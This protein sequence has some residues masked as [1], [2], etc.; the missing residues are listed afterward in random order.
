MSVSTKTILWKTDTAHSELIFKVKH[1]GL[2][3]ITGHFRHFAVEA[4]TEDD[5]FTHITDIRLAASILSIDTNSTLRDDHLRSPDFFDA[6]NYPKLMFSASK[7]DRHEAKTTLEGELTIRG[8]TRLIP[9]TVT[10]E[11]IATDRGQT[12]AGFTIETVISRHDFGLTWNN[13]GEITVDDDIR[14]RAS[15]QL[16]RQD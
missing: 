1:L 16:V 15:V 9:L 3:T 5:N 10:F 6:E 14:I 12:K 2:T 8:V 7:F 11:G 4:E 13:A